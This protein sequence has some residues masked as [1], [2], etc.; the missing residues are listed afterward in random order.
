LPNLF[1]AGQNCPNCKNRVDKPIRG[2]VAPHSADPPGR[3][4]PQYT[5][6]PKNV[7]LGASKNVDKESGRKIDL[8][9][10][11][12]KDKKKVK[13][14]YLSDEF[15]QCSSGNRKMREES[16]VITEEEIMKSCLDLEID[17]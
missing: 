10:R 7:N 12:K 15:N 13:K 5:S 3:Q 8:K 16:D 2:G 4:N 17:G 14:E 9:N 1:V 6:I 11:F